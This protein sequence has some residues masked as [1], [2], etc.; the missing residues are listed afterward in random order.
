MDDMRPLIKRIEML[1]SPEGVRLLKKHVD[2]DML[3]AFEDATQLVID[4]GP[5][6]ESGRHSFD[7]DMAARIKK[8]TFVYD[9]EMA[10]FTQFVQQDVQAYTQER[11]READMKMYVSLAA[12]G[13][14]IFLS[15]V[16]G[17]F[18]IR[19]IT[20]SIRSVSGE[21][22]E[23]SQMGNRLSLMVSPAASDL[24]DGCSEQASAIEEIHATVEEITSMA[25]SEGE[26]VERVLQLASQSDLS[27]AESS[28]STKRC[29]ARC[30]V[31]RNRARRSP[32]SPRPSRRSPSR[33]TCLR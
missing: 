20:R 29:G 28:T 14:A 19:H 5:P 2:N 23:A 8:S 12:V 21:L 3:K 22:A 18:T 10:K 30:S 25:A 16:G 9:E 32:T 11:L 24:A 15:I 26:R 27:A 17:Y 13:V 6:P 1:S 4:A 33:P 31:F 7:Q